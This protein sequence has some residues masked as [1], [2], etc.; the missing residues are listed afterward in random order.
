MGVSALEKPAGR[1]CR[2][3]RRASGCDAY[4][5]RPDDCRIFNCL[6]LLTEA[7]DEEWKPTRAGFLLHSEAGG[8]RLI[9]ECDPARPHDWRRAPYHGLLRR[10]AAA[11]QEVLV[12]AGRRGLR[13]TPGGDETPVRRA[14]G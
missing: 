12:F 3:F 14:A 10:W 11:G 5:D 13:L 8:A 1:W 4:D 6:W 2:R 9:V 7:L